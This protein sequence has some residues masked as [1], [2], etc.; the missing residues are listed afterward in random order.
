MLLIILTQIPSM[1]ATGFDESTTCTGAKKEPR[2]VYSS[3]A[4]VMIVVRR[5]RKNLITDTAWWCPSVEWYE[6][7]TRGM[8]LRRSSNANLYLW[9]SDATEA[10]YATMAVWYQFSGAYELTRVNMSMCRMCERERAFLYTSVCVRICWYMGGS[11]FGTS[12]GIEKE[13][14]LLRHALM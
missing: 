1:K 13:R 8:P 11:Q 12:V 10:D 9:Q 5:A 4:F 7:W 3:D 14:S 2:S 6:R